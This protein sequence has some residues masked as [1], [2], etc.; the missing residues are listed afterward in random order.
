V[1]LVLVSG[2]LCGRTRGF[3]SNYLEA[4]PWSLA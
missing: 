4:F 1:L 3:D 2:T